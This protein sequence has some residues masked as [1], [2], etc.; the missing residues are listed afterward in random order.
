MGRIRPS[1]TCKE[2][3][4]FV[5]FGSLIPDG[6]SRHDDKLMS[7]QQPG[8]RQPLEIATLSLSVRKRKDFVGVPDGF[9]KCSVSSLSLPFDAKEE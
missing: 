5:V 6:L 8:E 4:K 3:A 7:S 1:T 2:A 9:H